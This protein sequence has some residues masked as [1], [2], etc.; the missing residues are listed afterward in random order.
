VRGSVH[1]LPRADKASF[2]ERSAPCPMS[3]SDDL[4]AA[5]DFVDRLPAD[6]R[7]EILLQAVHL[8]EAVRRLGWITCT[9][10]S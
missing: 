7:A 5:L 8:A 3:Q 10:T 1:Y 2:L 9:H 4:R 6:R